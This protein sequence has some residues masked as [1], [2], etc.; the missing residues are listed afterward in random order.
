MKNL[1]NAVSLL[2]KNII[3]FLVRT[4]NA[5]SRLVSLEPGVD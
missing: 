2:F 5:K 1:S 4:Y 3:L